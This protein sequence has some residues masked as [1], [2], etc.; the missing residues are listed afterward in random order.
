MADLSVVIVSWNTR[1]LLQRCLDVLHAA[2]NVELEVI[3]VDNGSTD[4]SC[5][6]VEQYQPPIRLVRNQENVGFAIANN[7]G[8]VLARAPIALLLNSDAF[9]TTSAID[10]ALALLRAYP[11]IG[12]VGTR[13]LNTDGSVQAEA[14]RFPTFRDDLLTSLGLEQLIARRPASYPG[15]VAVDW[16]QGACMFVRTAAVAGVGGLD[17]RFF[18]YSEEVD[19]CRRFWGAGWQVWY[20][21]DADVVHVGSASS[22]NDTRRRLAL[23]RSRLGFRRRVAGPLASAMLWFLI[24]LGLTARIVARAPVQ[25]LTRQPVGRQTPASDIALLAALLRVDPLA[26][27]AVS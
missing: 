25:L 13:L 23:Y 7:T 4:G 17:A 20:L 15:P 8:M 24:L 14:G 5:E 6:M 9:I 10:D 12:V 27:W 26:R 22:R 1:A 16:V 21:P 18:M 19:W 3:V 11:R 2:A